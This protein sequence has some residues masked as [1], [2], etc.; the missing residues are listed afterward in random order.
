MDVIHP[1]LG[2]AG[3]SPCGASEADSESVEATK[4]P[5]PYSPCKGPSHT[6]RSRRTRHK[7]KTHTYSRMTFTHSCGDRRKRKERRRVEKRGSA[8]VCLFCVSL[9]SNKR[10]HRVRSRNSRAHIHTH[11]H[12]RAHTHATLTPMYSSVGR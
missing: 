9:V 6:P 2:T 3:R 10:H 11:T 4:C 1:H 7:H 12:V 8:H 5:H